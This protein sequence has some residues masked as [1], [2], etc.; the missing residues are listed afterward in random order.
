MS[1][2]AE[3]LIQSISQAYGNCGSY[4]DNGRVT[5]DYGQGRRQ[6]SFDTSFLRDTN[7]FEFT[8]GLKN[9]VWTTA[10]GVGRRV[11]DVEELATSLTG[12]VNSAKNSLDSEGPLGVICTLL[13]PNKRFICYS[14]FNR[15]TACTK[16]LIDK[17]S[18]YVLSVLFHEPTEES[19][20]LEVNPSN[21]T[22]NKITF[23]Q[24]ISACKVQG[25]LENAIEVLPKCYPGHEEGLQEAENRLKLERE[26][27]N[28]D[29]I[30]RRQIVYE[31]V[32]MG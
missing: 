13:F 24:R 28:R 4:I 10:V 32:R 11:N 31:N 25:L 1:T 26:L 7:V 19:W 3:Q 18:F 6:L 5:F 12:L 9:K 30:I 21:F 22:I 20:H 29:T 17:Q 23:E 8:W 15:D 14:P 16:D 27:A 2:S